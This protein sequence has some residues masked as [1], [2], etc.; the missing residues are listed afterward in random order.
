MRVRPAFAG[1]GRYFVRV[2]PG[3][4]AHDFTAEEPE[5]VPHE[6]L[7]INYGPDD[8]L[9][10]EERAQLFL[11]YLQEQEDGYDGEFGD[12]LREESGQL[13]DYYFQGEANDRPIEDPIERKEGE[14]WVPATV[15]AA[16][17]LGDVA[18]LLRN[19]NFSV[20]SPEGLLSALEACGVDNARI[21][22]EGGSEVPVVDGSS[23]MWA[24]EIQKSGLVDAPVSPSSSRPA[25]IAA[26]PEEVI[27][28]QG[29]N[30]SFVTF[31]P[32]VETAVTAGVDFEKEAPAIGRQWYSWKTGDSTPED[33]YYGH[34]RW[35]IA[36]SRP[37]FPSVEVIED[38]FSNGLLSA[39]P[40]G[41]CLVA[42]GDE[43]Y[44]PSIVRFAID[45]AARQN[46]RSIM[47]IMALC[48]SPGGR[49]LPV[50]HIV[51]YA[52]SPGLQLKFAQ[53]FALRSKDYS[54]KSV[55]D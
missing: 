18:V 49:G 35:N 21:E 43:W 17:S 51:S 40:D 54:S 1:E 5:V 12:Y 24:L 13:G 19:G 30:G 34:Y 29:E 23:M 37:C 26:A 50:G 55:S 11:K 39:G 53:E 2:P 7:D 32:G 27:V 52:A 47:G 20:M 45:E 25:R 22:I 42:D 9:D 15:S 46:V 48:A 41:C 38:L 36:P 16:E 33:D 3:T 8:G 10:P 6:K 14:E 44:D 31:Y 28:V 4:N